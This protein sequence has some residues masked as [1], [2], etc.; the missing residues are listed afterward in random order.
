MPLKITE[1]GNLVADSQDMK[2]PK[3]FEPL[4]YDKEEQIIRIG[5]HS[6]KL[7]P[8]FRSLF[9]DDGR[10]KIHFSTSWYHDLTLLPPYML[11]R[12]EPEGRQFDYRL[13]L[14]LRD[15]SV[16]EFSIEVDLGGGSSRYFPVDLSNWEKE[17]KESVTVLKDGSEQGGAEQPATAP[18]SKSEGSDKPKPRSVPAPR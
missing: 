7:A 8:Y 14:N 4:R 11:M 1:D 6:M 3:K 2:V 18:E 15:L 10:Y 16:I 13:L 12:I 5:N 17:I 9:P